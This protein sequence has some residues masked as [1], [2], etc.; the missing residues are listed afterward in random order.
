VSAIDSFAAVTDAA[1][2]SLT[3]VARIEVSLA[4]IYLNQEM[5]CDVLD[6]CL[7]VSQYLVE[8]APVWL[9]EA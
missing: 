3:I 4:R 8:R 2:R 5:L 9:D 7:A 6:R 1:E